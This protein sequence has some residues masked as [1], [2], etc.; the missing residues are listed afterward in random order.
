VSTVLTCRQIADSVTDY[1]E[2]TM[3]LDER[4]AFERHVS[5]CPPCRGYL[6]QMRGLLRVAGSLRDD[7]LPPELRVAL[8]DHFAEWHRDHPE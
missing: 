3:P 5:L 4:I 2:G 1:L 7:E 8:L 6:A